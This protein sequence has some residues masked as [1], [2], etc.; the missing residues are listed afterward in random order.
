MRVRV[1]VEPLL[2]NRLEGEKPQLTPLGTL[3]QLSDTVPVKP[4]TGVT[5]INEVPPEP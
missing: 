3:E 2:S 1:L 4:P 5:V